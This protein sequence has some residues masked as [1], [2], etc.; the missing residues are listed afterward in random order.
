MPDVD[1]AEARDQGIHGVR[2]YLCGVESYFD[3]IEGDGWVP[4]TRINRTSMW[5]VEAD[6]VETQLFRPLA[7]LRRK[8]SPI[9]FAKLQHRETLRSEGMLRV[10][11]FSKRRAAFPSDPRNQVADAPGLVAE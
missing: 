2:G 3:G 9:T 8:S 7:W 10:R 4:R 11:R 1:S 5:I 6:V